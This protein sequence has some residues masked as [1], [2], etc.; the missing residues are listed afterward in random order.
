MGVLNCRHEQG[1]KTMTT[2]NHIASDII[3]TV[4]DNGRV[5][6]SD[7]NEGLFSWSS[8]EVEIIHECMERG[9]DHKQTAR[10]LEIAHVVCEHDDE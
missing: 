1:N 4:V 5:L 2:F 8:L 10:V 3:D 6:E 7:T 9:F